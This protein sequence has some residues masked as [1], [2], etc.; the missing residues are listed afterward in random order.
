MSFKVAIPARF[1]SQRLPGKPLLRIAGKPMIQWVFERAVVSGAEDVVI[2][3][4]DERIAVCARGFGAQVC[5]TSDC[6]NSGSERLAETARLLAWDD[7]T[8][9]VNLQGDEPLMSPA[10]IRQVAEN[11]ATRP[12]ASIATLCTPISSVEEFRDPNVCKVVRDQ[13]DFA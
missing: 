10:N 12:Q 11:L 8:I 9:V 5:M 1:A 2:A 3:T 13:K 6:H 4:D 7:Q